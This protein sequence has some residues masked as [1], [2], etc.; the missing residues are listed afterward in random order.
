MKTIID[1]KELFVVTM[2]NKSLSFRHVN[3]ESVREPNY[4][5]VSFMDEEDLLFHETYQQSWHTV[6]GVVSIG[7]LWPK[8]VT[9][10]HIGTHSP[11]RSY[12]KA[13]YLVTS[14]EELSEH[15]QEVLRAQ[16]LFMRG[17]EHGIFHSPKAVGQ[18]FEYTVISVCDSGD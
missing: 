16:G 12:A 8:G 17:Q 14:P 9:V 3:G 10:Q 11:Y 18:G 4:E 6:L 1:A 13:S 15:D 2:S 5:T 7:K